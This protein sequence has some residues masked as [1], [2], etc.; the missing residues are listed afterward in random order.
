MNA[1]NAHLN[2]FYKFFHFFCFWFIWFDFSFA[3][4]TSFN[5][6]VFFFSFCCLL[7]NGLHLEINYIQIFWAMIKI[8]IN[9]FT[10]RTWTQCSSFLSECIC[11]SVC[12]LFC[13]INTFLLF[14]FSLCFRQLFALAICLCWLQTSPHSHFC[15]CRTHH[16][17]N[18]MLLFCSNNNNQ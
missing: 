13:R 1:L 9:V 2:V 17:R 16:F 8:A 18:R 4:L 14:Y 3:L 11:L 10:R 7:L 6:F 15:L 12:T 5:L